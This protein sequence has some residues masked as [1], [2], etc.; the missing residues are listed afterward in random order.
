MRDHDGQFP[1]CRLPGVHAVQ[2]TAAA[3]DDADGGYARFEKMTTYG[4]ANFI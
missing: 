2:E 4:H 3:K 1:P